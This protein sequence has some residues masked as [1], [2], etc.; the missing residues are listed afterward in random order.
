M[1]QDF[2]IA[3]G[4][5][6][7]LLYRNEFLASRWRLHADRAGGSGLLVWTYDAASHKCGTEKQV[8]GTVA[9]NNAV[10]SVLLD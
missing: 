8:G 10:P 3:A 2:A 4:A 5:A 7:R 1:P 6:R 9:G